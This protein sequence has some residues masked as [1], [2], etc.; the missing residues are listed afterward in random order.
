V[1]FHGVIVS[2]ARDLG[3]APGVSSRAEG[4]V[5]QLLFEDL[6]TGT[7]P[8]ATPSSTVT[9][10]YVG[11]LYSDGTRFDSSWDRGQQARFSLRQVVPGFAEAVGGSDAVPPMRVGGRGVVILPARL[12]YGSRRDGP[13]PANSSLV[14]VADLESTT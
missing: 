13:V 11:V 1:S 12:A 5:T 10:Q 6:V 14:F 7:R 4:P 2:N 3:A 9:V 8:A